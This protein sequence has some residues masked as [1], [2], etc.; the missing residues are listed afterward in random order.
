MEVGGPQRGRETDRPIQTRA[1]PRSRRG[2]RPARLTL[3]RQRGTKDIGKHLG[4]QPAG[5][6]VVARAMIAIDQMPAVRQP[7]YRAVAETMNR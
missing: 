4:R 2:I 5:I 6:R 1:L 3:E 7:M